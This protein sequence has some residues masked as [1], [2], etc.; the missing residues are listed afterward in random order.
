MA[1][2]YNDWLAHCNWLARWLVAGVWRLVSGVWCLVSGGSQYS[3]SLLSY[4]IG[5]ELKRTFQLQYP[6]IILKLGLKAFATL[7]TK[8]KACPV[9][10]DRGQRD[11]K[12]ASK[13]PSKA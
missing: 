9:Q 5:L 3:G 11:V 10:L 7:F 8:Y 13:E 12:E 1:G 4:L 6:S 2:Y